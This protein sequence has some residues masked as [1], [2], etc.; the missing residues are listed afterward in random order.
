MKTLPILAA[1]ALLPSL[2]NAGLLDAAIR[3]A[4]TE[5]KLREAVEKA[6]T[7][8]PEPERR[9]ITVGANVLRRAFEKN[10]IAAGEHYRDAWVTITGTVLDIGRDI[11][12]NAYV[13]LGTDELA[14]VQCFFPKEEEAELAKLRTGQSVAVIGDVKELVIFHVVVDDCILTEIPPVPVKKAIAVTRERN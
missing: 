2:A 12:G 13:L 3:K 6:M 11:L 4:E 8:E 1:L 5:E 14:A 7:A 10:A 9:R